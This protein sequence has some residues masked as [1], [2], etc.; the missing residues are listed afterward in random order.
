MMRSKAALPAEK[1]KSSATITPI[2]PVD[3][4]EDSISGS[5]DDR[6]HVVCFAA[7]TVGKEWTA[8][9]DAVDEFVAW[10]NRQKD[11]VHPADLVFCGYGVVAPEYQWNDFKDDVKG[12]IIV[13]LINDPTSWKSNEIRR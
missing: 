5:A 1:A 2:F 9:P 10:S 8:K 13:V 12:K 11:S 7:E 4:S 3:R 6:H